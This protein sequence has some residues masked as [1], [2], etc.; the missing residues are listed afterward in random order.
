MGIPSAHPHP[1][2][3]LVL[4]QNSRLIG[5][6]MCC[7]LGCRSAPALWAAGMRLACKKIEDAAPAHELPTRWAL[8]GLPNLLFGLLLVS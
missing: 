7:L 8:Q 1:Q 6:V 4:H 2:T 3:V 5:N